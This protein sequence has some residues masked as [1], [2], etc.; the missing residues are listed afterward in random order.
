MP[1]LPFQPESIHDKEE[2]MKKRNLHGLAL[3]SF[4]LILTGCAQSPQKG[5][6]F[7]PPIIPD[8]AAASSYTIGKGDVLEII[9]W[10]EPDF[11]R[12][13]PVRM[14]GK[15]SFPLLED[16][17]AAG[18]TTD[19]VREQLRSRLEQFVTHPIVSVAVKLQGSQRFYIVGQ[20]QKPGEYPILK[21]LTVLQ[22]LALAGGFTDWASKKEI[23]VIR[24]E[25]G[26]NRKMRVNYAEIEKGRKLDQNI[27]LQADDI[28]VVP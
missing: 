2:T 10:K 11:S 12:E 27:R 28:I 21:E 1:G 8:E 9:T 4:L 5:T 6:T 15:I 7:Q 19:E 24:N 22:A 16:I 26:A 17:Q 13:V 23:L 14:D 20:V 25:E 18:R 3:L